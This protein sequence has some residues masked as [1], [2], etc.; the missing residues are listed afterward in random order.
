MS[1][2][3]IPLTQGKVALIDAEDTERVL[4]YQWHACHRPPNWYAATSAERRRG[5]VIYL[6]RLITNAKKGE[7]VDHINGDGLDCRRENLRICTNAENRRNMRVQRG[8]S[9]FKGVARCRTSATRVWEAYIWFNNRKIALGNYETE[10][11]AARAY[12]AAAL[13]YHRDFACLNE[14]PEHTYEES[15]T[16]PIRNRKP[17]RP[18]R[19]T[20]VCSVA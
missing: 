18:A 9:R 14:I 2:V 7:H 12:N 20:A 13:K 11:E 5:R 19:D 10:S 8:E 15:I 3:E 6:H 16:P 1:E 17:G 4:K